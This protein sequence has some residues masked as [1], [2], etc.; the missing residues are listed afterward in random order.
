[1]TVKKR[2][3]TLIKDELIFHKK[4]GRSKTLYVT[5]KGKKI[6]K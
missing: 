4:Q 1:V 2:I 5:K 3:E 6:I